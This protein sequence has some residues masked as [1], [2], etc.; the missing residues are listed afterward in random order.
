MTCIVFSKWPNIK[1]GCSQYEE[2]TKKETHGSSRSLSWLH[3]LPEILRIK[4]C[5]PKTPPFSS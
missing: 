4:Y 5:L 1:M 2:G 3:L